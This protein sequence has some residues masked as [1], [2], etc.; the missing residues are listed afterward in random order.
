MS[1]ISFDPRGMTLRATRSPIWNTP[2]STAAEPSPSAT[3]RPRQRIRRRSPSFASAIFPSTNP[4]SV[5]RSQKR[6]R[7][8]RNVSAN[9]ADGEGARAGARVL[10]DVAPLVS[11]EDRGDE[12]PD[13]DAHDDRAPGEGSGDRE[14]RAD[15]HQRSHERE[16]ERDPERSELVLKRRR[17]VGVP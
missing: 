2:Y 9:G 14:E 6:A 8:P 13:R 17:R 3:S 16:D 15:D 4:V 1:F 11:V 7:S 5:M 12:Q 10:A